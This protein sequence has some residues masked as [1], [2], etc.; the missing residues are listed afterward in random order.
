MKQL[1]DLPDMVAP[2]HD[3]VGRIA[4]VRLRANDDRTYVAEVRTDFGSP[5][6]A[7]SWHGFTLEKGRAVEVVEWVR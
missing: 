5:A 3:L 7:G 1:N 2:S 4:L 6:W